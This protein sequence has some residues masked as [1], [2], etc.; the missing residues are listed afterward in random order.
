MNG[1]KLN[2]AIYTR[3]STE[4]QAK[5][6]FSLDA[7]LEKLKAY[8]FSQEYM[9]QDI[10][11]DD[12]F[13]GTNTKRPK[14]QKM[15]KNIK[16]WDGI[17]VMKMDR[18]HRNRMNFIDM[19][20]QLKKQ[21]KEFVSMNESYNTTTAM[22]RF[23]MGFLQDL[24]QLE[25]EQTGERTFIGMRQKAKDLNSGFIGH[26][27]CFGYKAVKTDKMGKAGKNLSKLV[28][29]PEELEIVKRAF[30]L[31]NEG[32]SMMELVE[33]LKY[34]YSSIQYWLRNTLYAGFYKWERV[35][36]KADVKP[37]ISETLWNLVQKRK[38]V[39]VNQN[40]PTKNPK[41][42]PLIIRDKEMFE[43]PIDQVRKMTA[44]QRGK[45]NLNV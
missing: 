24:A 23:I 43:I 17:L 26:R 28:P 1:R 30:E 45:H 21:D 38:S 11:V 34:P 29:I 27:A 19:M 16:K 13:T 8:C 25:S 37:I 4:D 14:Y 3:V 9:I 20:D 32:R 31:Y 10:Y 2:V 35:I 36:R 15:L 44:V 33:I 5:Q 42:T 12:G 40:S 6:G 39:T 22:G 41:F 18:I 7:Q